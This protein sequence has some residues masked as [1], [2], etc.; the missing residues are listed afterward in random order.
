M[1]DGVA[2]AAE[3]EQTITNA[4]PGSVAA[5][6]AEPIVGATLGAVVP[7]E[8]YW[9]AIAEVCRRHGVLL[10]A[11]EVM[12]GF[13][14]SGRWFALDHWGVRPDLLV[15]AKGASSGYWPFG[16]VAAAG[17][18]HDAVRA[19][20]AG[21]I[22]GFTYSHAPV[23][24]AVAR[25]VLRILRD[26]SLVEASATK[27]ER[28]QG[29]LRDRLGDH[30]AVGEIRGRGLFAGIELVADRESRRAYPR[31]A[32]VTEAVVAG[33]RE[34]GVLLYAGTGNADG[35]NGDVILIGPP[36][37]VTDAELERIA[38]V[39]ADAIDV[40]TRGADTAAAAAAPGAASASG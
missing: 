3:L 8:D 13:G 20:G 9:P 28:L 18:I 12:T 39:L 17:R 35:S 7:P 37:V 38:D 4:G 21:F 25:E 10:I 33:A 32:R 11:D 30:P 23:G 2:L 6:V 24:A 5:F 14:R 40:A 26:E 31:A 22:H 29:L 19:P 27:G 34:R 16:F 36:F 15:A 1:G